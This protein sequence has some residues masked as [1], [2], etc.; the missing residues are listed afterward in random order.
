VI[1]VSRNDPAH[2]IVPPPDCLDGYHLVEIRLASPTV[3]AA[4]GAVLLVAIVASVPLSIAAQQSVTRLL[5]SGSVALAFGA[6]GVIVSWRQ[7]RNP[8][9]WLLLG[10]GLLFMI[11]SDASLYSVADYR[12]HKGLPVGLLAVMFPDGRLPSPC[13]RWPLWLLLTIGVIVRDARSC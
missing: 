13:W 3:A 12:L 5:G 9:G 4:L 1:A 10:V 2:K 6:V 8:V 7:P 11:Q